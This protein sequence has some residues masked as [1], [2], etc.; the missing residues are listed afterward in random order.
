[1]KKIL[2]LIFI[3][4]SLAYTKAVPSKKLIFCPTASNLSKGNL[5]YDTR[6]FGNGGVL[7]EFR[8][9]F[10]RNFQLGVSYGGTNIIGR[11]EAEFNDNPGVSLKYVFFTEDYYYPQIALGFT[12]QGYGVWDGERYDI[13]SRGFYLA[14]SKNY[15]LAG[16]LGTFGAHLGI[17]Y[18]VTE[19]DDDEMIDLYLGFDKDLSS[20]IQ[21]VVE[22]DL[23]LNDNKEVI[24]DGKDV[25]RTN[26]RGYLNSGIRFLLSSNFE[27]EF[28]YNDILNNIKN[29]EQGAREVKISYIAQF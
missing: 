21:L 9:A 17:N 5:A 13:K 6:I 7:S 29:T 26:R 2:I 14:M 8:F 16:G 4:I 3:T 27:L 1:M 12:S 18:T 25:S 11:E 24:V 22:Y 15:I 20:R 23:A 19:D 28:N 10:N